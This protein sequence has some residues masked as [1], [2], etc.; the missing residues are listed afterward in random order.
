MAEQVTE[1]ELRL[2]KSF[3]ELGLTPKADTKEDLERWIHSQGIK[4]EEADG[5]PHSKED[6]DRSRPRTLALS[7]TPQISVFSGNPQGDKQTTFDLW[8]FEV[9]C[10]MENG[11]YDEP[12]ILEAIRRSLK[13]EAA[14]IA[15]RLGISA[16]VKELLTKLES[17]FGNVQAGERLLAAFYGARQESAEDVTQWSCRL[18]DL[19]AKAQDL[20]RV[21]PMEVDEMLRVMFYTGLRQELKDR[22]GHKFDTIKNFDELRSAIRQIEQDSSCQASKVKSISK[23]AQQAPNDVDELRAQVHQ[24]ATELESVKERQPANY[25]NYQNSANYQNQRGRGRGRGANSQQHRQTSDIIC[26]RC[27]EKGH[28]R[29]GCRVRLDHSKQVLNPNG[30]TEMGSM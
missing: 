11:V 16:T 3:R 10:L 23:A 19:L 1:E 12:V 7:R 27:G 13:G 8:K 20:G 24:L 5:R 18:E 25:G 26:H 14:R 29:V 15:M 28:I 4:E 9:R 2:L 22:T 30:P 21:R 17:V 6:L